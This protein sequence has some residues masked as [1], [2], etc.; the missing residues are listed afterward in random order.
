M[1]EKVGTR[2]LSNAASGDW[3]L[4]YPALATEDAIPWRWTRPRISVLYFL[5]ANT[6][7]SAE[8]TATSLKV[9]IWYTELVIFEPCLNLFNKEIRK[10]NLQ[11]V[12]DYIKSG[13]ISAQH[14]IAYNVK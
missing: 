7:D 12:Q 13:V 9:S 8:I 6:I 2:T 14:S 5:K 10:V 1:A 4:C 11:K 3:K